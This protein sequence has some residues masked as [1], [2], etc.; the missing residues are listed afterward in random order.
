MS[1]PLQAL[2]SFHG[3]LT[4]GPKDRTLY[5]SNRGGVDVEG[6]CRI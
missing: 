5:E 3:L 4:Q 1:T 6:A 2:G